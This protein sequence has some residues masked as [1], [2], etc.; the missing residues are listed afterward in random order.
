M[1]I[2]VLQLLTGFMAGAV[3]V[4]VF[5]FLLKIISEI[6][7]DMMF[8]FQWLAVLTLIVGHVSALFQK[9]LKRMLIYSSLAHAGYIMMVILHSDLFSVSSLVY[10]LIFYSVTNL[11]ALTFVMFLEKDQITG[12]QTA[13]IKGLYKSHL[14]YAFIFMWFL[15]NLAGF[16]PTAGFFA[17]V[18][19]LESLIQQDQLW[20]V[21]W[22]IIGS[23]VSLYYYL[24]PCAL[25]FMGEPNSSLSFIKNFWVNSAFIIQF[26]LT[27]Y[28][29]IFVGNLQ[30]TIIHFLS[31][32]K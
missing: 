23:V 16:P 5:I 13:S 25:M 30:E 8:L 9:N 21:F 32:F 20:M 12:V 1:F 15:L 10:Y 17:K 4:S 11:G 26:L 3:K 31:F 24:R 19:I 22:L 27:V 14:M 28:L 7:I 2:K 18:F 29:M 6:K